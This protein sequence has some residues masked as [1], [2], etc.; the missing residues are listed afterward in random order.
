MRI[1]TGALLAIAACTVPTQSEAIGQLTADLP[2][3]PLSSMIDDG[4][5]DCFDPS[6]ADQMWDAPDPEESDEPEIPTVSPTVVAT[7]GIPADAG[8]PTTP[9][10]V[11]QP[12][13]G[14]PLA[15]PGY[16]QQK[17]N[18]QSGAS[19]RGTCGPDCPATCKPGPNTTTCL[20]WQT[21]DCGWHAKVCTYPTLSCGSHA[22]CR[23]HDTCYDQC[24]PGKFGFACRRLCDKGC[25]VT[26]G[27][28]KCR[29]WMKGNGPYDS[30]IDYAG[31]ATSSTYDSTCY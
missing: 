14:C 16:T 26:Y 11:G 4:G 13:P 31:K 19:C 5:D 9:G 10:C 17:P 15:P 22:G 12:E 8:V 3:A 30:W 1:H 6:C 27:L 20:E 21:A 2:D 18:I 7:C 24:Q 29:A 23:T 25:I 28:R